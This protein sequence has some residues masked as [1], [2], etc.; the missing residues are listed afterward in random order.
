MNIKELP[1]LVNALRERDDTL[2]MPKNCLLLGAGCSYRS[3]IPLGAHVTELLK[4]EAFKKD[5]IAS[6]VDFIVS[7]NF[8]FDDYKKQFDRYLADNKLTAKYNTYIKDKRNELEKEVDA[9]LPSSKRL[10]F[11]SKILP[12]KSDEEAIEKTFQEHKQNIYNDYEYGFWFKQFSNESNVR[13]ELMDKLIHEKETGYGYIALAN[14]INQDYIRNIFTT[15]FDDLLNEALL[16]YFFKKSKIIAHAEI[17]EHI[18]FLTSKPNI[19]KLHGDYLFTDLRNTKEEIDHNLLTNKMQ[20]AFNT[21]GLIVLGY[22]GADYAIMNA[23]EEAKEY[24]S[25]NEYKLI[26]CDR[27]KP[28]DLHWRVKHLLENTKNSFYI[29]IESFDVLMVQI[30][31]V[32]NLPN[33]EIKDTAEKRQTI[34]DTFLT[35]ARKE[36][37][38]SKLDDAEK[39]KLDRKLLAEEYF[40]K[41]YEA[42]TPEE[43]IIWYQRAIDLNPN[44][45]DAYNNLGCFLNELG[46]NKE[47]IEKYQKAI[48][49]NPNDDIVYSNFGNALSDLGRNKEAIENHKKAIELNPKNN[50]AYNN[51]GDTFNILGR[52]EEAIAI[53]LKGESI[54]EG[55]CLYNLA[56]AYSLNNQTTEALT[57]L[58]KLFN[59][60]GEKNKSFTRQNF[61]EDKDFKSLQELPKFKELLNK[62]R[63]N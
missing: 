33:I 17:S 15:N 23:L 20:L 40:I 2:N 22:G 35:Q 26:W 36:I 38:D 11:P 30:N 57:T 9:L 54:K 37:K 6:E 55:N 58:E 50:L 8:I 52:Y 29:Q 32:L 25:N 49:L 47:A 7:N 51:L 61:K 10:I 27:K 59:D 44:D 46:R 4:M 21:F 14:I 3:K 39:T 5:F 63:P 31:D 12:K 53:L 19:I 42:N 48:D 45:V 60:Q 24:S 28:E 43:K 18:N 62:Y 41:G 1:F 56:C 13:A 16:L 34:Y